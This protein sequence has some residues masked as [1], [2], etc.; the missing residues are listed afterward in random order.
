M[1][2]PDVLGHNDSFD[3]HS[4]RFERMMWV[5]IIVAVF[6]YVLLVGSICYVA[7]LLLS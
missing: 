6:G 7:Y 5:S 2:G 4:R 1:L 3:E